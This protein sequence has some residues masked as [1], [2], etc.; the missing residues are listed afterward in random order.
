MKGIVHYPEIAVIIPNWNR[1]HDT[2]QCLASLHRQRY[3]HWRAIVV[4]NGS[5]DGSMA[6]LRAAYPDVQLIRSESN[7]GFAAGCNLGARAALLGEAQYLFYLNNDTELDCSCLSDLISLGEGRFDVISPAIYWHAEPEH[8]WSAGARIGS[9]FPAEIPLR[10]SRTEP[11]SA[12]FVTGCAMLVDRSVLLQVG[13]FDERFFMYYEDVEFC[14]RCRR[15][16]FKVGVVPTARVTHKVSVSLQGMRPLEHYYRIRSGILFY[17]EAL[18][19][20]R[21]LFLLIWLLARLASCLRADFRQGG[22]LNSRAWAA[23]IADALRR[24]ASRGPS[25]YR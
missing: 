12:D 4:D 8:L 2:M 1:P 5:T 16:G 19:G 24:C 25:R 18:A 10:P 15:A 11:Y 6:L 9:P 23:G 20:W 7:V 3:P 21:R 17:W 22:L 13:L 14:D